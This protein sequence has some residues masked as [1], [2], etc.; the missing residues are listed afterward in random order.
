MAAPKAVYTTSKIELWSTYLSMAACFS[1][2]W[3]IHERAICPPM[4]GTSSCTVI[5]ITASQK[6][7]TSPC[8][9]S[10]TLSI[11]GVSKRP[12][13]L[14]ADALATAADT[15]P[16]GMGVKGTADY[17]VAGKA[18]KNHTP[19]YRGSFTKGAKNG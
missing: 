17:P 2:H 5:D 13:K 7:P 18:H 6:E 14:E 12:I 16:R 3:P 1:T 19:T 15:L 10:D 9:S 11:N 8:T 4:K